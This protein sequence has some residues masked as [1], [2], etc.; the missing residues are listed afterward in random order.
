MTVT[1]V[2]VYD[3]PGFGV[4]SL[5]HGQAAGYTTGSGGIAWTAGDWAAH[6]GAIRIDQDASAV[7][8]TADILDVESGAATFGDCPG[9][10]ERAWADFKSGKRPGQRSPAI[11]ADLSN[12]PLVVDALI[13]GGVTSGCGLWVADWNLNAASAAALV[14]FAG[15]A[16][17]LNPFPVVGV[18]Y[19]SR[20]SYDV[21]MFSETWLNTV[22]GDPPP[23]PPPPGS[24]TYPPPGSLSAVPSRAVRL[25]WH[26]AVTPA[27]EPSAGSYTI[28]IY[29]GTK[30]VKQVVTTGLGITIPGLPAGTFTAHVWA[31]G[32]PS[33]PPH[34]TVTFSA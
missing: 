31:N 34:A 32:A 12:L 14:T 9:W 4:A 21:N 25:N 7:D 30:L 13:A 27:H 17:G 11:Y 20:G 2:P 29:A 3:A 1:T 19:G 26:A 24:W 10:F 16:T 33:A 28:A 8:P 15:P 22:S 5:P 18:Q 23:P 6:P